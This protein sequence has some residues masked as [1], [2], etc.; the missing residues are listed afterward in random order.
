MTR[1]PRPTRLLL[2][3]ALFALT[4]LTTTGTFYLG[5]GEGLRGS[6]LFGV[7]LCTI[8]LAHEMGHYVLARYHQVDTSLPYFIP[9][10]LLGLGTLGAVIR[11]R[12]RIPH[13]NA[14]VDIGAAG[15]LAGLAVAIPVLF[16]GLMHSHPVAAPPMHTSFPGETSLWAA[17][18]AVWEY[19]HPRASAIEETARGASVTVFGDNLLILALQR[20]AMGPLPDGMTAE[21]H[22]L[23]VAG[24][25]GTLVTMLNLLPIGQLDGGHMAYAFLGKRA[26]GL[27]KAAALVLFLLCLFVTASWVI[28]LFVTS[29]FI[30]FR[31]PEVSFPEEPLS[32]NRKWICWLCLLALLICAMPL[33]VSQ[34]SVR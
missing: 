27:G 21:A 5:F 14:L 23:V 34:L 11:I 28:W 6:V 10:P 3:L 1:A 13:R 22:P 16:V 17:A 25:F 29:K 7:A 31:H 15:P 33:P 20:L 24:W 19:F 9:M 18:Q 4:L 26:P 2:H 32:N 12:G 30:G 8:L